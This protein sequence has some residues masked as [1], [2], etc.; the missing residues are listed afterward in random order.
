MTHLALPKSTLAAALIGSQPCLLDVNQY[1]ILINKSL[2]S[3]KIS[4]A[5]NVHRC[6]SVGF[7]RGSFGSRVEVL[8]HCAYS[9]VDR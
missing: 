3:F 9:N 8:T 1:L 7:K 5:P 6:T 4:L 2:E